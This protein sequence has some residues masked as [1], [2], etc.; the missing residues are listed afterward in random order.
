MSAA[1]NKQLMQE[2][3]A[4]LA[5]GNSQALVNA[6]DDDV[7]WHVTGTTRFSGTY[8]GK[9]SLLNDL[10][11]PL[12]SQFEDQYTNVADRFIADDDYVV[13][14]CRGKA[15]TKS[16]RPYNNKYCFVFRIENGKIKD[17]TEYMDTQ[18][19]VTTFA[20]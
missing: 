4:E 13:V 2:I 7:T 15:T 10:V 6:L 3:F 1:V 5:Q 8:R 14:E 18:L 12:F 20:S 17:V 11:G 16:G 9:T 19:V